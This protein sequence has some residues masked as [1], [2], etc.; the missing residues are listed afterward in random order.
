V[1][2]Q[3][4]I[5]VI[6]HFESPDSLL[7][8]IDA[9]QAQTH[10]VEKIIL[11]DNGSSPETKELI[12]QKK[13]GVEILWNTENQGVGFGHN[14]GWKHALRYTPDHV[15]CLEHDTIPQPHCLEFLIDGLRHYQ[16]GETLMAACPVEDDGLDYDRFQYY[17]LSSNGIGRLHDKKKME[18]Y[19][20]GLTFN[21]MLLPVSTINQIG[22]VREDL[23]VG[24]EDVDYCLRIWAQNGKVLKVTNAIVNHNLQKNKTQFKFGKKIFLAPDQSVFRDYYSFRNAVN[25]DKEHKSKFRLFLSLIRAMGWTLMARKNKIRSIQAKWQGFKDGIEGNL[26]KRNYPFLKY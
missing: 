10:V 4:V 12:S 5:A 1:N 24:R 7:L 13:S 19:F 6:L 16:G 14:Q 20:G 21:G 17:I 11:V 8:A 9:I 26:G 3:S 22:Y 18:N 2:R 25:M 15:W 23:F